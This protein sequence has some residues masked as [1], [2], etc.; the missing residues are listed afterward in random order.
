MRRVNKIVFRAIE[1]VYTRAFELY[2]GAL[3]SCFEASNCE[4]SH[5][6]P[7]ALKTP[8][9]SVGAAKWCHSFHVTLSL[10]NNVYSE[11]NFLRLR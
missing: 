7:I 10:I 4:T 9:L 2:V 5:R 3:A 11:G 8:S 6:T 1:M